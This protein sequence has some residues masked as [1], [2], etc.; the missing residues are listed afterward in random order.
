[1]AGVYDLVY[2]CVRQIPRG[3]VSTYGLI[4]HL[5][6]RRLSPQA[7]G[8]A[9][10]ALPDCHS[11]G[12]YTAATVPWHRVVNARGELSTHKNPN[13]PPGLQRQYLEAEGIKF[14]NLGRIDLARHLWSGVAGER[15]SAR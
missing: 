4:S 1:M 3:R 6:G 15:R 5:I 2:A 14:D 8:W 12:E 7:V 11:A 10:K 13:I 9:L